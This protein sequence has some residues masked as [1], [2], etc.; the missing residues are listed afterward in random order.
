MIKSKVKLV[1]QNKLEDDFEAYM[2]MIRMTGRTKDVAKNPRWKLLK[3]NLSIS[4][5]Q[6]I[7]PVRKQRVVACLQ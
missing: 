6:I 4:K 2:T 3:L 5:A 7:V 1:N